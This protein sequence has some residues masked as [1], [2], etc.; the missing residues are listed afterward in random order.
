M[1]FHLDSDVFEIVK[2]GKKN[3]EVRLYDKKRENLVVGGKIVFL[4]RPDEVE[5]IH[6]VVTNIRF[7]NSI[8]ELLDNYPME[9]LFLENYTKDMFKELLERFYSKEDQDKYGFIAIE[10]NKEEV[11]L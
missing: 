8:E 3:V 9:R 11:V 4:K 1:I 2:N 10:F 6:A 5:E 7:F